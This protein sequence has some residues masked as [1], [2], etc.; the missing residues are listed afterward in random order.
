MI[1]ALAVVVALVLY[2]LFLQADR[3]RMPVEHTGAEVVGVQEVHHHSAEVPPPGEVHGPTLVN[4]RQ[5]VLEFDDETQVR[6][7]G[8][9][10]TFVRLHSR[11]HCKYIR[12][13]FT[14]W[15]YVVDV[16]HLPSSARR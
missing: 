1:W 14:N 3:F 9:V 6:W 15:I 16:D 12:G 7:R 10:P 13:R 8:D 5:I 4:V 11:V 2:Q